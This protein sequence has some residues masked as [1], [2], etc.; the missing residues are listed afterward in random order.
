MA[1]RY[2]WG[3]KNIFVDKIIGE[4]GQLE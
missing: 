3:R 2:H 4:A 1:F